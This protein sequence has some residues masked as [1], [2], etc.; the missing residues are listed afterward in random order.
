MCMCLLSRICASLFVCGLYAFG[1]QDST[2]IQPSNLLDLCLQTSYV[3]LVHLSLETAFHHYDSDCLSEQSRKVDTSRSAFC[4]L[5]AL[6][7]VCGHSIFL[8]LKLFLQLCRAAAV[9]LQ[10]S[11]CIDY[12]INS[13]CFESWT[14]VVINHGA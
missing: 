8:P 5:E 4:T 14:A 13:F 2:C 11:R 6:Q 9:K 3:R 10:L 7:G 12:S 1:D